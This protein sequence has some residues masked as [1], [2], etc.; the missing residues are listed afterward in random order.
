MNNLTNIISTY[1]RQ[2]LKANGYNTNQKYKCSVL[3]SDAE[4]EKLKEVLEAHNLTLSEFIRYAIHYT[5][6]SIK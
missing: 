4:K 2:T 5:T 6:D 3:Y 1:N